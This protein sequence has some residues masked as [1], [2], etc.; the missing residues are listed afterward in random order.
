MIDQND[1]QK[2]SES[3]G[4]PIGHDLAHVSDMEVDGPE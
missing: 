1:D 4:L 3:E 2:P